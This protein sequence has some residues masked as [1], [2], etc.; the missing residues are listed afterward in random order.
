MAGC[1]CSWVFLLQF[2]EEKRRKNTLEIFGIWSWIYD[3]KSFWFW[4]PTRVF[5]RQKTVFFVVVFP[6]VLLS[7]VLDSISHL[8]KKENHLPSSLLKGIC[9][10]S[11]EVFILPSLKLTASWPL[12]NQWLLKIAYVPIPNCRFPS[13]F[14]ILAQCLKKKHVVDSLQNGI[15]S[16]H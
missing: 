7:G 11:Q 13:N 2:D 3:H 1:G 8:C 6:A 14:S 16:N 5:Q 15:S 9:D 4:F 12:K 10:R